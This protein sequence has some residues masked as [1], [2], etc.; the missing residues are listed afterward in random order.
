VG[1]GAG[2]LVVKTGPAGTTDCRAPDGYVLVGLDGTFDEP[3][4]PVEGVYV[5]CGA[6]LDARAVPE[7]AD[8]G[9]AVMEVDATPP[10]VPITLSTTTSDDGVR[11]EPVFAPPEHSSFD[12]KVGPPGAIDCLDPAG[13]SIYRRVPIVVAAADL[14]AVLCVLGEDEA[15]NRGDPQVFDLP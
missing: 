9:V 14:P 6:S 8:A 15:G 2:V 7:T 5:L 4:P 10:S 1:G 13:Y 12:L 3:L 11:V